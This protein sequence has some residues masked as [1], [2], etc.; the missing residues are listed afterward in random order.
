MAYNEIEPELR[1]PIFGPLAPEKLWSWAI[2][3]NGFGDGQYSLTNVGRALNR[4]KALY[5]CFR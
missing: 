2:G 4:Y 5:R 3:V 1:P